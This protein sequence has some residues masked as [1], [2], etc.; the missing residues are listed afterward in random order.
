MKDSIF[1][2]SFVLKTQYYKQVKALIPNKYIKLTFG[3]NSCAML[4]ARAVFPVP[5]APAS[6]NALP[7][8]FLLL[9]NSTTTPAASRAFSWP[10]RPLFTYDKIEL[11]TGF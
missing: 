6:N 10:T 9:I 1:V 5:G 3:P 11:E 4:K 8:I 2:V 7:A